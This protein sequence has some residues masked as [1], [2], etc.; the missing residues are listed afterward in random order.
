MSEANIGIIIYCKDNED[1]IEE[2]IRS[3]GEQ[4]HSIIVIDDNSNDTSWQRICG[5]FRQNIDEIEFYTMINRTAMVA[6][7]NEFADGPFRSFKEGLSV[8]W[9]TTNWIG[10]LEGGSKILAGKINSVME[11]MDEEFGHLY[12]DFTYEKNGEIVRAYYTSHFN[13]HPDKG[14]YNKKMLEK[15]NFTSVNSFEELN[16]VV[17]QN[18]LVGHVPEALIHVKQEN[19]RL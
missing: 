7:Q 18:S 1:T 14:F 3:V 9:P 2:C 10:F 6:R 17:R 8:L 5:M 16:S 13:P 15:I 12:G 19:D 11:Y 4:V